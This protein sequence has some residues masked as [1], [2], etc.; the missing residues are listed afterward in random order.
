MAAGPDVSTRREI[1]GIKD[2]GTTRLSAA[3][4]T[5]APER[6]DAPV[7]RIP[8]VSPPNDLPPPV[9]VVPGVGP[10]SRRAARAPG[11]NEAS[12][13]KKALR[14]SAE[15]AERLGVHAI[16]ARRTESDLVEELI[17]LHLKR[18][19]VQDR[20]GVSGASSTN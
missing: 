6:P 12:K 18:Y 9:P 16:K 19:V 11:S 3:P 2:A 5:K 20:G 14:L 1:P 4:A 17:R 7:V 13:V 15:A 8:G 10:A